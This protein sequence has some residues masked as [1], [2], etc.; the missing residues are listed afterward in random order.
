MVLSSIGE[1]TNTALAVLAQELP[2][3]DVKN[4]TVNLGLGSTNGALKIPNEPLENIQIESGSQTVRIEGVS[5]DILELHAGVQCHLL[6]VPPETAFSV[7]EIRLQPGAELYIDESCIDR[8]PDHTVRLAVGQNA[9]IIAR[10][11]ILPEQIY[12]ISGYAGQQLYKATRENGRFVFQ[13]VTEQGRPI[14]NFNE[15][16]EPYILAAT[17]R[18][19]PKQFDPK[20]P[21]AFEQQISIAFHDGVIDLNTLDQWLRKI[22]EHPDPAKN[23]R[24]TVA[25]RLKRNG[26]TEQE[27]GLL[28]TLNDVLGIASG[29]LP[30]R[31]DAGITDINGLQWRRNR[32]GEWFYNDRNDWY[33]AHATNLPGLEKTFCQRASELIKDALILKIPSASSEQLA[34][35]LQANYFAYLRNGLHLSPQD[36]FELPVILKDVIQNWS[37]LEKAGNAARFFPQDPDKFAKIREGI[38]KYAEGNSPQIDEKTQERYARQLYLAINPERT[39]RY[40]GLPEE[41]KNQKTD[42]DALAILRLIITLDNLKPSFNLGI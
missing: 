40:A 41:E 42:N 30:A 33:E 6:A 1:R 17:P 28:K 16:A 15:T 38:R 39:K 12:E 2:E 18:P 8:L 29:G 34:D 20:N 19:D 31:K 27:Y 3:L 24:E 10:R 23:M 32:N 25:N 5:T 7:K 35:I 13:P 9:K 37:R 26:L 22:Q 21:Q 36:F 4:A 11:T 14:I